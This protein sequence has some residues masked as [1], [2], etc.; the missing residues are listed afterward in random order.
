MD[1]GSLSDTCWTRVSHHFASLFADETAMSVQP[2]KNRVQAGKLLAQH[3]DTYANRPDAIVLALPRGGVPVG[4]AV[5]Q[6]LHI[7]LDIMVVRKLG[8]PRQEELAMGAIAGN[9]EQIVRNE[10]AHMLNI[11][12]DVIEDVA[13]RERIELQRR[14]ALYRSGRPQPNLAGRAV[15]L[16]DDGLATGATMT[17]AA[18]A[19]RA[20]DPANL[21]IAVPVGAPD[22]CHALRAHAD[23]VVCLQK[24]AS[25]RAVS[26]WYDEFPQT[27]DRE[28]IDLLQQA[29]HLPHA[30]DASAAAMQ[31]G[32][33][34]PQ[35]RPDGNRQ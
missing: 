30:A 15:I 10:V 23:E 26:L 2:F 17:A 11:S 4:F 21:V 28:V 22:T 32:K 24:P 1:A 29:Q 9:G 16:V 31:A 5:A 33:N 12:N 13:R 19:V 7:P 20:Q 6:A 18:L 27:S 14:E 35:A 8:V 3:L 34:G 25:F